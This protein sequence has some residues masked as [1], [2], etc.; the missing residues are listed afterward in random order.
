MI[1]TI[2][3]AAV[4]LGRLVELSILG[5][6]TIILVIGLTIVMLSRRARASVRHLL[7]AATLA[8]VLALPMIVWAVP[9][10]IIGVPASQAG[11]STDLR[12]AAPYVAPTAP[13][14]ASLP[15][16]ATESASWALPS[17][18]TIIRTVWLAGALLL[19]AQ[20]AVDLRRLYRIRRDGLPWW[21]GRE[22]MRSLAGECGVRRKVEVLLHDGIAGPLTC[23]LWRPAI[24]LPDEASEWNEAD[25]R[26]A[27]IH[28]LEHVRRGDWAIQL[29]A[30]ATCVLYWPHPLVWMAFR[31]LSLES[32]RAADDAVVRSADHTEYAEQLVSLAGRLSKA[33]A[34]AA[35][36]MANRSDLSARVSALLDNSQRRGRAGWRAAASALSVASLVALAIAPVRAVTQSK[37]PTVVVSSREPRSQSGSQ[38]NASKSRVSSAL[39]HGLMKAAVA[40]DLEGI[41]ELINAGANV[42]GDI[43]IGE[44]PSP[45]IGA[46]REGQLEAV[47]L[48]L[49]RGADPNLALGG[50]GTPLIAAAREG[51]ADV[52]LLLLDRGASIDQTAPGAENALIQASMNGHLDVVKLLV[53]RGA[54]VNA[55]AWAG[56]PESV[57]LILVPQIFKRKA[58]G[59]DEKIVV[60]EREVSNSDT[61]MKPKKVRVRET[62][63]RVIR[64]ADKSG[65]DD[66]Q[67]K[68]EWRTPLGMARKGGHQ[69]VIK[70]LLASGAQE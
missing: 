20:L 49:D 13:M 6:A 1:S 61:E 9:E 19:L 42:N 67:G 36:G 52:V 64:V 57:E 59:P 68:G 4:A 51:R 23:G 30:R 11:E 33:Q 50:E 54:D 47:R 65:L 17:W 66:Q 5:K 60:V 28:E 39:D 12:P 38:G 32:E 69:A 34:Q 46:A 40:G 29:A 63:K 37:K 44:A 22:L 43:A 31:R 41:N 48:L 45:L 2:S 55:R 62:K 10:V 27:L 70:F 35:L 3:E 18:M 16:R 15:S 56:A 8:A 7:L 53:A 25:L 14:V 21:K 58:A 26:R 24:L